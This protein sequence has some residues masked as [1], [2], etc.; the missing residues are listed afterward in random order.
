M[1]RGQVSKRHARGAAYQWLAEQLGIEPK[2]CH[3][4]QMERPQLDRVIAACKP[5]SDALKHKERIA[6]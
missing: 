1:E 6:A 3:I 2:D 5:Y 4:S